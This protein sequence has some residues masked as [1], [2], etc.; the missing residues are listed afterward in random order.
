M[1]SDLVHMASDIVEFSLTSQQDVVSAEGRIA[2]G[3]QSLLTNVL[4][5]AVEAL[6][7]GIRADRCMLVW[8]DS[9]FHATSAEVRCAIVS[10]LS[11]LFLNGGGG[12]FVRVGV[13]GYADGVHGGVL[14]SCCYVPCGRNS[15]APA[16]GLEFR[17]YGDTPSRTDTPS[18]NMLTLLPL[19]SFSLPDLI[20]ADDDGKARTEGLISDGRFI[21]QI[22]GPAQW[23]KPELSSICTAWPDYRYIRSHGLPSEIAINQVR[24][25]REP[26]FQQ[27]KSARI[28]CNK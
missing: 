19:S 27:Q 8:R 9:G 28:S 7:V 17:G 25:F 6:R 14:S 10:S 23:L 3:V 21:R 26:L 5:D 18:A 20:Q 11:R 12:D 15:F 22:C 13:G 1:A 16:G 24:G 4:G 2:G